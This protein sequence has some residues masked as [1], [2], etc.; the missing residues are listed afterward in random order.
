MSPWRND[1]KTRQNGYQ[2]RQL[3]AGKAVAMRTQNVHNTPLSDLSRPQI[4]G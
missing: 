3:N 4:R 1:I 2:F